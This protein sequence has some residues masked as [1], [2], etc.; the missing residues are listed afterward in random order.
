LS[1]NEFEKKYKDW[2]QK[3]SFVKSGIRITACLSCI[4]TLIVLGH[5]EGTTPAILM[6]TIGLGLAE[7][8]GI[9]E[10]WI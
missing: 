4:I 9:A 6:L 3:I 2:H 10:E 5:L 1:T 7:L 8:L